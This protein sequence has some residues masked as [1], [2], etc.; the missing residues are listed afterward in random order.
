MKKNIN[1]RDSERIA[2]YQNHRNKVGEDMLRAALRALASIEAGDMIG[3]ILQTKYNLT[4][5]NLNKRELDY[6]VFRILRAEISAILIQNSI[7]SSEDGNRLIKRI[8]AQI[9]PLRDN[10][11]ANVPNPVA[12]KRQQI[13]TLEEIIKREGMRLEKTR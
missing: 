12:S 10:I 13:E 9:A 2:L 5:V 7:L 3:D 1:P 6:T 8:I 4:G 11:A